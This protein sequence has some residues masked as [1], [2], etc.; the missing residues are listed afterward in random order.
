LEVL[1]Q[2]VQEAH[3]EAMGLETLVAE[4]EAAVL[5]LEWAVTEVL[6]LLLLP[7]PTHTQPQRLL[8]VV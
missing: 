3:R 2:L 4:V 7:I 6:E 5:E 1:G 8:A